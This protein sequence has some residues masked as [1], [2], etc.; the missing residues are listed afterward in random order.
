VHALT[1]S[2]LKVTSRET[3]IAEAGGASCGRGQLKV[4]LRLTSIAE[5]DEDAY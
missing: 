1:N 4:T 5:A 2:Q 3:S